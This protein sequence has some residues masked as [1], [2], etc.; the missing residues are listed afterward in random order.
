M[1]RVAP[2]SKTSE[3]GAY[4]L[5]CGYFWDGTR[6]IQGQRNV[7]FAGDSAPHKKCYYEN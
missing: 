7:F 6:N 1:I 4:F 2:V 5:L 3:I